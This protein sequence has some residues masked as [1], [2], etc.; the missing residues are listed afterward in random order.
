MHVQMY[1]CV[2]VLTFISWQR[3]SCQTGY[4]GHTNNAAAT[5]AANTA[6][7]PDNTATNIHADDTAARMIAVAILGR[8]EGCL[9]V[10]H[11]EGQIH[12]VLE[13]LVVQTAGRVVGRRCLILLGS[14]NRGSYRVHFVVLG[15]GAL[16]RLIALA[17]AEHE[18]QAG[19]QCEYNARHDYRNQ[20]GRGQGASLRDIRTSNCNEER[21]REGRASVEM[22]EMKP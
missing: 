13:G 11:V 15:G 22:N 7:D 8:I 4:A 6:A 1:V 14:H 20:C 2:C 18:Q 9:L 10:L 5:D 17:A 21:E 16:L 3:V 12:R 19:E